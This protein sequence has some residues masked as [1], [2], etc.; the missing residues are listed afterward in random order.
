MK[1]RWFRKKKDRCS[2]T[3]TLPTNR[4]DEPLPNPWA[5]LSEDG[6]YMIPTLTVDQ[7]LERAEERIRMLLAYLDVE[8]RETRA[9]K[10]YVK[11]KH[12]KKGSK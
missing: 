6:L 7:R 5:F 11:V 9:T 2:D 10:R 12:T 4:D 8:E 3:S 1:L